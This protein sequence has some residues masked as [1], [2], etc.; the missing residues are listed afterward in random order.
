MSGHPSLRPAAAVCYL[1]RSPALVAAELALEQRALV[2][3][4]A[5]TRTGILG[6]EILAFLQERFQLADG[7]LSVHPRCDGEF[8]LRF[9]SAA[10]RARVAAGNTRAGRF[11][12][13]IHPWS[14]LA[15][16]EPVTTRF[17][18]NIDMVGI[19][20]HAWCRA[21]AETLLSPFCDVVDLAPASETLADMCVFRLS[22]WTL[23]PDAIPRLSELL[24]PVPDD[25]LA[26]A[27]PNLVFHFGR[28]LLRFPV[29]IHVSSSEDY[30]LPVARSPSPARDGDGM[31][32]P[33]SPP[34]PPQYPRRHEFPSRPGAAPSGR[35]GNGGAR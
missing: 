3:T 15:G 8:L 26:D 12:L 5:G 16:G 9:R 14:R 29:S 31:L 34:V 30:R 4:M 7:A 11:R 23:N 35:R 19:P 25:A 27:D 21:S 33:H 2:A 10:D 17:L 13:L 1:P 28:P 20:D 24:L 22:A 18:V 6:P 32:E